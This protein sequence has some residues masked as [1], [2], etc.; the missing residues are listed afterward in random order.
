MARVEDLAM[1][2]ERLISE[3]A[4]AEGKDLAPL[5]RELRMVLAE[6]DDLDRGEGVS[7][8]DQLAR[9][10]QARRADAQGGELPAVGDERG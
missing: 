9:K 1:L 4:G 3:I 8:V 5:A 2:R 6:L 7:V 10:R